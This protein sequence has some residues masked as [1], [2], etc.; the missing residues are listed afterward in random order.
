MKGWSGYDV[1]SLVAV[2]LLAIVTWPGTY[3]LSFAPKYAVMLL[4]GA[5]GLPVAVRQARSAS[6][7][8]PMQRL[9][10][11]FLLIALISTVLSADPA[12]G[13]FGAYGWG[14]GWLFLVGCVS[15]FALGSIVRVE[16]IDAFAC[17]FIIGGIINVL[18]SLEQALGSSTNAALQPYMGGQV[19]GLFANPVY[20]EM[21]LVG[22]IALTM[23]YA[24]THSYW[25]IGAT[26]LLTL[27]VELS[28]ERLAIIIIAALCVIALVRYGWYKSLRFIA[29]AIIGYGLGYATKY[30]HTNAGNTSSRL[31]NVAAGSYSTR[32]HIWTTSF[33]YFLYNLPLG[34]GP[35]Q[36]FD[37]SSFISRTVAHGLQERLVMD[38]HNIFVQTAITTGLL[39]IALFLA[40]WLLVIRYARGPFVGAFL[41]MMLVQLIEPMNLGSTVLLFLAAGLAVAHRTQA[42]PT[43]FISHKAW[44]YIVTGATAILT[45]AALVLGITLVVGD[46]DIQN[47]AYMGT[48]SYAA[49][50]AADRLLPFWPHTADD[51]SQLLGTESAIVA[52]PY[53]QDGAIAW[54]K[55]AT[56]RFPQLPYHWVTLGNYY[57]AGGQYPQALAAYKHSDAVYKWYAPGWI[58]Q[59]QVYIKQH[60]YHQAAYCLAQASIAP[61]TTDLTTIQHLQKHIH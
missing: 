60:R 52:D 61:S 20:Y 25:W 37:L 17:A 46:I 28:G 4:I 30:I 47:S 18:V 56:R 32:F 9:L 6:G 29:P 41:A 23:Y 22:C 50:S 3:S 51:I 49:A 33:R 5:V 44:S 39:G 19:L 57:Y 21:F 45:A 34:T 55:A 12:I 8:A 54:E 42:E 48:A 10:W 35:G 59:A 14:T 36:A 31:T 58:G 16:R 53:W 2:V 26:A 7:V 13:F 27:G 43:S 15:A 11:G 38:A 1:F 40:F 24:C